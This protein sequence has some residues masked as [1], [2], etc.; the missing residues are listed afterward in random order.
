MRKKNQLESF[1][2]HPSFRLV[3]LLSLAFA[4]TAYAASAK[5]SA[6]T[7]LWIAIILIAARAA[8]LVER[9][10]QS[11][12]LGELIVG[13]LLGNLSLV[14]IQFLE[15][16]IADPILDFLAQLGVVILLFQVG[17][18]SDLES[19]R[20]VG[21]RAFFVALIGVAVPFVLGAYV[22]GPWLLPESSKVA[23]LFRGAISRRVVSLTTHRSIGTLP[24]AEKSV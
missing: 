21:A 6:E 12:V 23:H 3:A 13:V 20:R 2:L 4:G 24:L 14:G 19:M 10:G 7:F 9:F 18:E 5:G 16:I 1:I 15:P 17:L 11:A 22:V 8:T